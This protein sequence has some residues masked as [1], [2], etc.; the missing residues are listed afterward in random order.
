MDNICC[1]RDETRIDELYAYDPMWPYPT[2]EIPNEGKMKGGT[3]VNYT[4]RMLVYF[5]MATSPMDTFIRTFLPIL[6]ATVAQVR[7]F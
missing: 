7:G 5:D 2:I 3:L 4:P 1:V 6:F